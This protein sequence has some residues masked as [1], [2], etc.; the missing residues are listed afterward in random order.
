VADGDTYYWAGGR[1]VPLEASSDVAIDLGS[2]AGQQLTGALRDG[3]RRLSS[4][5]VMVPRSAAVAALGEG[6]TSAR[7]VHP[8]FRSEDGSLVVVLPEV[9]VEGSDPEKLAA[10]GRSLTTATV[11]DQTAERLTLEPD[12]GRGEDALTLANMLAESPDTDL[13]QARFLRIVPRP[14]PR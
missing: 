8:V 3:G 7:G 9:R 14:G 11:K 13:A 1:K 2:P 12:S 4:S 10:L 5:L 6:G